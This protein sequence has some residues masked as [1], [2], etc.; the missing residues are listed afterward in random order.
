MLG[1]PD[2]HPIMIIVCGS[3]ADLVRIMYHNQKTDP[4]KNKKMLLLNEVLSSRNSSVEGFLKTIKATPNVKMN[5]RL[6]EL[7]ECYDPT[8]FLNNPDMLWPLVNVNF[9]NS[10]MNAV[11]FLR[12][13]DDKIFLAS[14][15]DESLTR[16]ISRSYYFRS[17][18]VLETSRGMLSYKQLKQ[19][20]GFIELCDTTNDENLTDVAADVMKELKDEIDTYVPRLEL[21]LF[22][23]LHSEPVKL[24][25]YLDRL[26]FTEEKLEPSVKKTKPLKISIKRS[27]N[28]LDVKYSPQ[29]MATW[30]KYPDLRLLLPNTRNFQI[31]EHEIRG[32]LRQ[33]EIDVDELTVEQLTSVLLKMSKKS[34]VNIFCYSNVP[35]SLREVTTYQDLLN[36]LAHNSFQNQYI[37][38][39][40]VPFGKTI[41]VLPENVLEELSEPDVQWT[42][43]LVML[44]AALLKDEAFLL[45][46]DLELCVP[47]SMGADKV[48]MKNVI[49]YVAD[50]WRVNDCKIYGYLKVDLLTTASLINKT[51]IGGDVLIDAYYHSF[52]K[53]Q[54]LAQNV[55]L[56]VGQLLIG[57][58]DV[59]ICFLISG[60]K[61]NGVLSKT[62]EYSF[63]TDQVNYL[64]LVLRTAQLHSLKDCMREIEVHESEHLFFGV[65]RT[66]GLGID[67]GGYFVLGL[68]TQIDYNL[69]TELSNP[70]SGR[71]DVV[72][73]SKIRWSTTVNDRIKSYTVS[74]ISV[75][76]SDAINL[77]RG[78]I[79][80]TD[81]NLRLIKSLPSSFSFDMLQNLYK[82]LDVELEISKNTFFENVHNTK[83]YKILKT[84]SD[85]DLCTVKVKLP[86]LKSF[87]AQDGGI[88]SSLIEYSKVDKEFDFKWDRI[89]TREYMNLKAT[90]P[91]AFMTNLVTNL[92]E[93]FKNLYDADDKTA[94]IKELSNLAK[95][96]HDENFEETLFSMLCNWGYIGVAGALE[97]TNSL[98]VEQSFKNI[99]VYREKFPFVNLYIETLMNLI[100][101]LYKSV[102]ISLT[103]L[104]GNVGTFNRWYAM[105]L[106]NFKYHFMSFIHSNVL[107]SYTE[108]VPDDIDIESCSVY[109]Y[110][111]LETICCSTL[112]SQSFNDAITS[113]PLLSNLMLN[114][115]NVNE[116]IRV[117]FNLRLM[118]L[119]NVKSGVDLE[120]T[121]RLQRLDVETP[122]KKTQ[123]LVESCGL[124]LEAANV[125][126]HGV[127]GH[128]YF[129]EMGRPYR[130]QNRNQILRVLNEFIEDLDSIKSIDFNVD[131]WL[132][133]PISD[134]YLET[135]EFEDFEMEFQCAEIDTDTIDQMIEDSEV[136]VFRREKAIV[137]KIYEGPLKSMLTINLKTL[138]LFGRSSRVYYLS[139]IRQAGVNV[140]IISDYLPYHA[141]RN[142]HAFFRFF[143]LI[144]HR[145]INKSIINP[146]SVFISLLCKY[147]D[148][149]YW[150]Q[151][152]GAKMI[153]IA[154]MKSLLN[155]GS[156]IQIS[157]L[158]IV[159]DCR[160]FVNL[161]ANESNELFEERLMLD[162]QERRKSCE[163]AS[164]SGRSGEKEKILNMMKDKGFDSE[165]IANFLKSDSNEDSDVRLMGILKSILGNEEF[166]RGF[167]KDVMGV[168]AELLKKPMTSQ[169]NEQ[170]LQIAPIMASMQSKSSDLKNRV[171]DDKE[172][173]A[174]L[175]CI[176]PN[177]IYK[178]ITNRLNITPKL[179]QVMYNKIKTYRRLIKTLRKN[180]QDKIFLLNL[181]TLII[182]DT[183]VITDSHENDEK[184][185]I[186]F[187]DWIN[188]KFIDDEDDEDIEEDMFQRSGEGARINYNPTFE[189]SRFYPTNK[190][191]FFSS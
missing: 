180:V 130:N 153:E 77:L 35:T 58:G 76:S 168:T 12:K 103:E 48:L 66:G 26:S 128:E 157:R 63:N 170:I 5:K 182:N 127:L 56:G 133:Y 96:R 92:N 18:F 44:L 42:M 140:A 82:N 15:Q 118:W 10:A 65:D 142:S 135:D 79:A 89:L 23:F 6:K 53:R 60:Q 1:I 150:E 178:I 175:N 172:L 61:I 81:E 107:K 34:D 83:I 49:K 146:G 108:R 84:C 19:I 184:V 52:V 147:G 163:E 113:V 177:C 109:L 115:E 154:E 47:A 43:S 166:I 126:H 87:P 8:D 69:R 169:Q 68:P 94:I 21:L 99:R 158:G 37:K 25:R 165:I 185:L 45:I 161:S 20:I 3:D 116:W 73:G 24:Y 119:E 93:N 101:I 36:L 104:G 57:L 91:E 151:Y 190:S 100:P 156:N 72:K 181:F 98:D 191:F 54:F 16:R 41:G 85:M 71:V 120:Y 139:K 27:V 88:L 167:K 188:N 29:E 51:P 50:Y 38:G 176:A 144:S 105:N 39:V 125:Y 174:E 11:K 78:L 160:S 114:N 138:V 31:I 164:T 9:R 145:W 70:A 171:L 7:K 131:Y 134:E 75:N 152:F 136:P 189:P 67:S 110:T 95:I 123:K 183:N 117:F 14:L 4:D 102:L 186:E 80:E 112:G 74:T 111:F 30:I 149:E 129:K 90:Q 137:T 40:A 62:A 159:E 64:N 32:S 2:A 46:Q 33:F 141:I 86:R 55:W 122:F 124:K 59:Q 97:T 173:I 187:S 162:E 155:I 148:N 143:R 179:W 13:L 28:C 132:P 121:K 106:D 22:K 17:S